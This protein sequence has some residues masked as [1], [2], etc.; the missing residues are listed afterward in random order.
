M[1]SGSDVRKNGI[2]VIGCSMM[3]VLP[4]C[5]TFSATISGQ[6]QRGHGSPFVYHPGLA[7]SDFFLFPRLKLTFKEKRFDDI[8]EI[9]ESKEALQEYEMGTM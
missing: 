5:F 6:E 1:L 9:Q 4:S 3:M 8:L 2:L 7:P